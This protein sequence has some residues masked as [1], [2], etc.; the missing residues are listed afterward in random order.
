MGYNE[1]EAIIAAGATL[2]E[3]QK[4]DAGG[5]PISFKAKVIAWYNLHKLVELHASDAVSRETERRS[6]SAARK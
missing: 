3:L 6:S 1:W 4:W 5:Y 2:D